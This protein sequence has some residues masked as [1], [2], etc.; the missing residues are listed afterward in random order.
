MSDVVDLLRDQKEKLVM[1]LAIMN[2]RCDSPGLATSLHTEKYYL[3]RTRCYGWT[4][5]TTNLPEAVLVVF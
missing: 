4:V 2:L 5:N 1:V 3:A